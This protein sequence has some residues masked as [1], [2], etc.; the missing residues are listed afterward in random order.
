MQSTIIIFVLF[1]KYESKF[2][3]K[4]VKFNKKWNKKIKENIFVFL[5]F[6]II[7]FIS[8]RKKLY[9]HGATMIL[10]KMT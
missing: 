10:E 6:F 1:A 3:E 4:N 9:Q 7:I 2:Y 5:F 8:P